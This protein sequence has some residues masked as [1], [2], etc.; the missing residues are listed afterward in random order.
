MPYH[1]YL[2]SGRYSKVGRIGQAWKSAHSC[3]SSSTYLVHHDLHHQGLC[4]SPAPHGHQIL[5]HVAF[6]QNPKVLLLALVIAR[7]D[8]FL[9][10]AVPLPV[11]DTLRMVIHEFRIALSPHHG[12]LTHRPCSSTHIKQCHGL[13]CPQSRPLSFSSRQTVFDPDDFARPSKP[14][15]RVCRDLPMTR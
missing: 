11:G 6:Y 10:D 12:R 9:W 4:V 5:H 13:Q 15:Q 1:G 2:V 8:G 3:Q 14:V 7:T